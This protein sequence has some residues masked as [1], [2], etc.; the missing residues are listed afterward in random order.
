MVRI[1]S[2][3]FLV[4]L[5]VVFHRGRVCQS[6]VSGSRST[7]TQVLSCRSQFTHYIIEPP[8]SFTLSIL[9]FVRCRLVRVGETFLSGALVPLL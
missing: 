3:P 9:P 2:P 5:P 1:P 8:W 4:V 6:P 7:L